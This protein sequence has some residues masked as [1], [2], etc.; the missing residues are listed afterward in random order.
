MRVVLQLRVEARESRQRKRAVERRELDVGGGKGGAD[1]VGL[2]VSDRDKQRA[3]SRHRDRL[4]SACG[5]L[6]GA[7][8]G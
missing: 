7:V 2:W 6:E 3:Q 1:E 8:A 5:R 4:R